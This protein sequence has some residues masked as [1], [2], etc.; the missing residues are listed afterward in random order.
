MDGG[1]VETASKG[2][3]PDDRRIYGITV[4]QVIANCDK[5]HQGRV[6]IRLAWLPGYEP[7]ARVA[8]IMAGKSRGAY[9]M[10]KVGDEVLVAFNHGDVREPYIIGSLW[11]DKDSPPP[12]QTGDP[13]NQSAIRTAVGHEIAFD[14]KAQTIK[15]SGA[16]GGHIELSPDKIEIKIGGAS[17]NLEKNGNILIKSTSDTITLQAKIINV[18]GTEK[19]QINNSTVGKVYIG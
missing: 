15:I 7:W 9:F 13:V 2:E 8:T 3:K 5:M 14:D 10:P 1:L 18:E 16:G 19:V 17:I 4:A 11:N 12:A 6:Q